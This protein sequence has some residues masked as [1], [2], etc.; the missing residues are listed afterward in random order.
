MSPAPNPDRFLP[1]VRAWR[2]AAGAAVVLAVLG[3]VLP[4]PAAEVFG[5]A[6]V[7]VVLI[8]PLLRVAWLAVRWFRRGD[9]RFGWVG[10][11]VLG[12][13]GLAVV[14]ASL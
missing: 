4:E 7:G 13:V 1:V 12:V 6:A 14:L 8:S 2:I 5:A 3:T 11:G 10:V 9:P